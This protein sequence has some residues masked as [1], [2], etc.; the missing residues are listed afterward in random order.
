[1][2]GWDAN[3]IL[4]QKLSSTSAASAAGLE[5]KFRKQDMIDMNEGVVGVLSRRYQRYVYQ[6]HSLPRK[7]TLKFYSM[8]VRIIHVVITIPSVSRRKIEYDTLKHYT[9]SENIYTLSSELRSKRPRFA[10][11]NALFTQILDASRCDAKYHGTSFCRLSC[12]LPDY[13]TAHPIPYQTILLPHPYPNISHSHYF[14]A[15]PLD[16]CNLWRSIS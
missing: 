8:V 3:L 6:R 1:M 10:P 5:S 11:N 16:S 2:A 12:I 13:L 14:Y 15:H 7:Y 4:I 9:Y